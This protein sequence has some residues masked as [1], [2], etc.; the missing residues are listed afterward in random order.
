MSALLWH[1]RAIVLPALLAAAP[2]GTCCAQDTVS[3][4]S[5]G[6]VRGRTRVAG[7]VRDFTG[8]EL[9]LRTAD[10]REV[11][12][13]SERVVDIETKRTPE[14]VAAEEALAAGDTRAA[15]AHFKAAVA[16]EPRQWMRRKLLAQ[17]VWCYRD[18]GEIPAAGK[19]FLVLVQS[20][21]ETPDFAALP[22]CWEPRE[23]DPQLIAAAADWLARR[24]SPVAMLLGASCLLGTP[25][26][27]SAVE[28][29]QSLAR[30]SDAR[31]AGLAEAQL[32]RLRIATADPAEVAGWRARLERLPAPLA[33]GPY[34][35]LGLGLARHPEQASAAALAFLRVPILYPRE[36]RLA[37]A[38]LLRAAD[39]LKQAGE[40]AAARRL[41]EELV[42]EH[43]ASLAGR[44]AQTRLEEL[45]RQPAG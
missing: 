44:E 33:A 41:Y 43:G 10:G 36:R 31:I 19:T 35:V 26:Q 30:T 27:G 22:L 29:L 37:A 6:S 34:Y 9:T 42:A 25:Q 2:A 45:P 24:E 1:C 8:R 17:V 13:P 5:P 38:A 4:A 20:D 39:V 40:P 3:L 14:Q 28:R 12:Y 32:W 16:A 15:L 11:R 21:P 18:L 23:P 7:E